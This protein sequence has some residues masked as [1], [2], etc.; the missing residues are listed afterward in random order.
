MMVMKMRYILQDV[1]KLGNNIN[2]REDVSVSDIVLWDQYVGDGG[3]NAYT[4][5]LCMMK[6]ESYGLLIEVLMG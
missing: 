1:Q 4:V 6:K 3:E 2:I 5:S